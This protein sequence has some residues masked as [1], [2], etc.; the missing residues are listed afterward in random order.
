MKRIKGMVLFLAVF[1]VG[2]FSAYAQ[3]QQSGV[4]Q[5]IQNV[6][7]LNNLL[8]N[9]IIT[10]FWILITLSVIYVLVAA[11]HYVT[12]G[13]DTEKTSKA[14]RTLTYAAV[15]I[16]IALL[17]TQVPNIVGSIFPNLQGS[18]LNLQCN[19]L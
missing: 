17:S 7:Q 10:F 19:V 9:F 11:F 8:C 6:D 16:A 12:A 3:S 1:F 4:P 15:G 14:R 5:P 2:V 13:D 18:Q